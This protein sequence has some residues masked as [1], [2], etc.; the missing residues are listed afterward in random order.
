MSIGA[1][2][3]LAYHVKLDFILTSIVF[4]SAVSALWKRYIYKHAGCGK[5]DN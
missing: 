4:V 5:Y 2:E 3:L 1:F